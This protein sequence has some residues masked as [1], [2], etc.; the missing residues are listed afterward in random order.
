MDDLPLSPDARTLAA[1]LYERFA[2]PVS[3]RLS[4]RYPG[5]DSQRIA[6]AIVRAIL[7]LSQRF[8]R[9]QDRRASLITFLLVIASRFLGKSLLAEHRRTARERE[10]ALDP[11]TNKSSAGQS[12][13]DRLGDRELAERLRGEI[14]RTEEERAILDLW[15]SGETDPAVIAAALPLTGPREQQA[16]R[17]ARILARLRQRLHRCGVRY[18][19]EEAEG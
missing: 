2:R 18:R 16:A 13:L 14:A 4:R 7:F 12:L 19:Q 15:L 6:D 10:K 5:V 3:G 17:V 1:D 9:Y 11:V 8:E